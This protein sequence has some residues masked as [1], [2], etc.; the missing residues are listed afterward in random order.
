MKQTPQRVTAVHRVHFVL[1]FC[2][3]YPVVQPLN[4]S[5]TIINILTEKTVRITKMVL[6][7]K[8]GEKVTFPGR[9]YPYKPD[10][11][12]L[13]PSRSGYLSIIAC[14]YFGVTA[15]LLLRTLRNCEGVDGR[16]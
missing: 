9:S 15:G 11:R 14:V 4:L 16:P 10:L 7:F 12:V 6:F 3:L 1:H 8:A 13:S 5:Y 2:R